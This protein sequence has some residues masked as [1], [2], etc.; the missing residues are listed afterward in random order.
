M[1]GWVSGWELQVDEHRV[2]IWL[3]GR[4]MDDGWMDEWKEG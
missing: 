3:V 4:R 2:N 1:D